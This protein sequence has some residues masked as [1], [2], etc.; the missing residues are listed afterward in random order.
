MLSKVGS[1][2]WATMKKI[3]SA[4]SNALYLFDASN[5]SP[6]D[7]LPADLSPEDANELY[8]FVDGWALGTLLAKTSTTV[9]WMFFNWGNWR[10]AL[11][12]EWQARVRFYFYLTNPA[13]FEVNFS[14]TI[15]Q[16]TN[17]SNGVITLAS[18]WDDWSMVWNMANTN[19]NFIISKDASPLINL[20]AVSDKLYI[21]EMWREYS[22]F[23]Q[24]QRYRV[25]DDGGATWSADGT[26]EQYSAYDK[27]AIMLKA[28]VWLARVEVIDHAVE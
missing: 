4:V 16:E 18:D 6:G 1:P 12:A 8:S 25:S 15:N 9:L 27:F 13:S 22:S 11:W 21:M 24:R 19:A 3:R 17:G 14:S 7:P 28:G 2:I 26:V 20:P 10:G 23:D 5:Y